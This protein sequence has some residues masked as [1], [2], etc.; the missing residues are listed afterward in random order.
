MFSNVNKAAEV[1][2]QL[3]QFN[4]LQKQIEQVTEGK[5][6]VERDVKTGQIFLKSASDQ[7][8]TIFLDEQSGIYY[9]AQGNVIDI[10]GIEALLEEK[11]NPIATAVQPPLD[12]PSLDKN[13]AEEAL[14]QTANIRMQ[15]MLDEKIMAILSTDTKSQG[16]KQRAQSAN[17]VSK[18]RNHRK[19]LTVQDP[20]Q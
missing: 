5:L 4:N 8:P 11:L 7:D 14:N 9:D 15:N 16:K 2:D 6:K 18:R 13:P 17:P 20:V 19:I 12:P 3:E 10:E 1:A